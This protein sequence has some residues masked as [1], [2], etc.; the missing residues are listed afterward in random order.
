MADQTLETPSLAKV[1]S[2]AIEGRLADMHTAIPAQVVSYDA[3]TQ[4]AKVQPTIKRKYANGDLVD[5]PVINDVPVLWPRAGQAIMHFPLTPADT[6]LLVFSE[7]SI[8]RWKTFGGKV[9]PK[10]PRK[11]T[12]S[13]AVAIPG[14]YPKTNPVAGLSSSKVTIQLTPLSKIEIAP[15]GKLEFTSGPTKLSITPTGKFSV[16]NILGEFTEAISKLFDDIGTAQ[17]ATALGLQPLI[18]PTFVLDKLILDSFK[19]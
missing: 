3:G 11:F 19:A 7:R 4:R 1:I 18:M 13:D 9:D 17:T 2:D 5:L 10:D 15:D 16:E 8:D 6:V 14:C 12:L